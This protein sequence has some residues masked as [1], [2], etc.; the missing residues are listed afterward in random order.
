MSLSAAAPL[1]PGTASAPPPRARAKPVC[2]HCGAP[3]PAGAEFCCAGC[4]YVFR[5]VNEAGLDAYY[6]IKD[7]VTTPADPGLLQAR[8]WAWLQEAQTAAEARAR[9]GM[10]ELVLDIQGVSCAGCVWLIDRL[11]QQQQIEGRIETNAQTGQVRLQWTVPPSSPPS[12]TP[13]LAFDAAAFARRLQTFNYLLGP[14]DDAPPTRS[15]S[16]A[17]AGRIGLCAAFSMNVMLFTL[18]H[19]F[20]ME[21]SFTY[22]RLFDTLAMVFATLS[23]LA[24]GGYFLK[25]AVA[26]LRAR[27]LHIDLPIALGIVGAYAGSLVGWAMGREDY[28][29]FDFVAPF[30][31][32]ML[33]GRWAQIAAI[34]R[35][36][37]RLLRRQ[38]M[39]PRVRVR[40]PDGTLAALSPERVEAGMVFEVES[41]QHLP[42]EARLDSAEAAFSLAWINGEAESRVFRAGQRVPA[43][44]Q[45]VSRAP[46]TFAATQA[47]TDSLLARLLQPAPRHE[48]RSRLLERVIQAYLVGI[49]ALATL[50]GLGWLLATGDPVHAGAIVTAILVVSCPCALGLAFPLV[51]E[52][53]TVALRRRGVFLKAADVWERLRRVRT[54]AFDKTGTLTLET[55]VLQNPHALDALH[56]EAR[57]ALLALVADNPHP[58]SRTLHE[59]VLAAGVGPAL[60]GEVAETIGAGV[61]LGPWS[62]GKPGWRDQAVHPAASGDVVLAR[63]GQALAV[64][65]LTDAPRADA[66][67]EIAA[68]RAGGLEVAILSGDRHEKV[69]TL[70]RALDL[71]C[72]AARGELS[73]Q[74]KA[75]WV[76]QHD[77]DSVLMLG[78]GANDSLAF[79]RAGCRGTPIIHR[80]MLAK[81]ADFYYLGK[82][83]GGI[84]ALLEVNAARHRTQRVLLIFMIAYNL[85][86]VGLATAGLMAPLL[87]AVL[88]PLSSL[89]TLAIVALGMRHLAT[90]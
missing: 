33:V 81:R 27:L 70:A 87:A 54:L 67:A 37:R 36:Q 56:P 84:R 18:P 20:G 71:P 44:A 49:L 10:A 35:N 3:A 21:A 53:A 69:D 34:E 65:R 75:D 57:A 59:A 83:I 73:P 88:M 26:A 30:I 86:T 77:A 9:H 6:D 1:L 85:T 12:S 61:T 32:L 51:E 23:L 11:F 8:D 55:P 66:A 14:A 40:Q 38:P 7:P 16:R 42:V 5:L 78:D 41:G 76:D 2:R 19:Y 24:G 15:E 17:L 58:V 62:L 82:G 22:A 46:A 79:D 72:G 13:P 45:V 39:A 28:M 47:W 48:A 74:A 31:L 63:D 60:P 68:L 64:F 4:T 25:R 90:R 43:G 29:Y 80:G 89:A 52:W 50:A